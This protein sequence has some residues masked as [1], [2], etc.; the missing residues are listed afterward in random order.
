[1]EQKKS[2]VLAGESAQ[3]KQEPNKV[4]QQSFR[5]SLENVILSVLTF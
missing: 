5:F 4:W 2:K 1:M 3:R